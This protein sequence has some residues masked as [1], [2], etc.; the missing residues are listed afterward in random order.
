[1]Q[2]TIEQSTQQLLTTQ[3]AAEY[4]AVTPSILVNWRCT[5]RVKVPYLK[6]GNAVRYRKSDLDKFLE[7]QIQEG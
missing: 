2:T 4:L 6:I 7:Q 1:M 5:K 3:Q